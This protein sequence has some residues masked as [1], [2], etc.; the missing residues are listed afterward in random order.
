MNSLESLNS[1]LDKMRTILKAAG[2]RNHQLYVIPKE[3]KTKTLA[4]AFDWLHDIYLSYEYS[5]VRT[6]WR[7]VSEGVWENYVL[8]GVTDLTEQ[9]LLLIESKTLIKL[10]KNKRPRL[11]INRQV[12]LCES[13]GEKSTFT[14]KDNYKQCGNCQEITIEQD[15]NS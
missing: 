2:V 15:T 4:T 1:L 14:Y 8:H 6:I 13:C 3:Y 9:R 5:N 11:F 7:L 12:E 10:W